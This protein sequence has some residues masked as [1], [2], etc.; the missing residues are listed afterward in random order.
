MLIKPQEITIY[1]SI[2]DGGLG[3][4]SVRA[5]SQAILIHTFLAQA[6]CP[7]FSTNYY[8][9]SLYRWHVLAHRDLEDPGLPPYYSESFFNI[10]RTVKETSNLCVEYITVRQWYQ[11]LLERG[12]T[13]TQEVDAPPKLIPTKFEA[14]NPN[15]DVENVYRLG[16][17]LGLNPD[18]KSFAFKMIQNLL[19]TRERLF[20]IRK[21]AAP[22]C[23]F[24]LHLELD[25]FEHFFQ[26]QKYANVMQPV[27]D[28]LEKVLPNVSVSKL[29]SL[30]YNCDESMEL[31]TT[32]LLITSMMMVWEARKN[33]RNLKLVEFKADLLA[34]ASLL[35]ET[36]KRQYPLH[37]S[38]LI[39]EQM[40]RDSLN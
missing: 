6:S 2:K 21:S 28:C 1:R 22:H 7:R 11:I 24:C 40:I 10:I 27:R 36:K 29:A 4:F 33:G 8:L 13:H 15:I 20:R 19:P 34:Q 37:N 39:L 14:L 3:L 18:Q 35:R 5:R 25:D 16:R 12:I 30:S 32:W 23:V 38:A 26:C 9:N 31:P 17:L